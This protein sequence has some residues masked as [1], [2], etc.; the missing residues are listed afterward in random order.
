[1]PPTTHTPTTYTHFPPPLHAIHR[2]QYIRFQLSTHFGANFSA[3]KFD[4]TSMTACYRNNSKL[5]Q[6]KQKLRKL[7]MGGTF[8]W[9]C[10]LATQQAP[11]CQDFWL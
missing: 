8:N 4:S 5:I 11:S 10:N 7:W 9:G 1:M 6:N 2:P 3:R